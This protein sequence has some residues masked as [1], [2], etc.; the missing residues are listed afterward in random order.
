MEFQTDNNLPVDGVAGKSTLA[1]I[2]ELLTK[3]SDYTIGDSGDHVV[4][5]K[6]NLTLLGFGNFPSSPSKNYGNVTEGVVKDFQT[7]N[8]LPVDG[9]AGKSTLA[10]IEELL[11]KPSDY[12][13]GDS[14]DHIVELKKNLTLLGFGNFPSSPSKNYGSVTEGV[15]K[16]FQLYYGLKATGNG[17]KKTLNKIESL[18][19]SSY[20]N[21]ERGTHVV[22]LKED[23]TRLGFVFPKNP[24]TGYGDVTENRVRDIQL[25]YGLTINGIEDKKTLT[26][27]ESLLSSS[28]QNGERGTHVVKLK[29]DLTRLGFVF[30]KNPSTGYGDV[31]EKRVREFQKYYG[32]T[33]NGIADEKTL[34]K[35]ES[36]L[37]SSYQNGERGTHVVKLK[38]DLTRLGFVFPKNP[39]T[40]Y[41]DVTEKRVREFQKYYGLTINGIADEQTLAKIESLLSSS[42]QNGERGTHV[43][44]LIED[45]TRLG[46]VFPKNPS[47]GYGDVT[48]KRVREFQKYYGLTINGIADE[49]TLAK[50]E[51]LLS[52]SYQ[53]GE[54]GTHVVK[55][56]EDLTRLGFVFP[57]NPSTGYGDVTE[58]RVR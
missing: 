41:G 36:L 37:S 28:Y 20:Q 2:E 31:T 24:S 16:D 32:L 10:K 14:G 18:L 1:K 4:E 56:K 30:P 8:N 52:S 3:P 15:V 39:S 33:I 21:G 26:K 5:L 12:T 53:N 25:Y 49:K 40:G 6:K 47:T 48:E 55:L 44:K 17:D 11:T 38:E 13:I 43:V 42:Y 58:K 19:S 9:V 34:A 23:L 54:R 27:I 50:I 57:K 35:I 46:F 7:D 29:E 45:L 22:K 51:S